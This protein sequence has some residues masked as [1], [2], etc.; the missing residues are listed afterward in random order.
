[1]MIWPFSKRGTTKRDEYPRIPEDMR[2][3]A[4]GDIHGRTDLLKRLHQQILEDAATCPPACEKVVVY[5][6]DY[7]DRGLDSRGVIDLLSSNPLPGFAQVCL[8]GNHEQMLLNFL[9]DESVGEFWFA[10]GGKATVFSYTK[11]SDDPAVSS[12]SFPE[13]QEALRR[14]IPEKHFRFFS[15][16]KF[17]HE[18]GDYFF[19]HAGVRPGTPIEEQDPRDLLWIR[20]EF[21]Q[22]KREH[23][24]VVVHGHSISRKPEIRANR[25]NV[26]T[27]AYATNALTCVVLEGGEQRMISTEGL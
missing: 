25:I 5:V 14:N 3:F 4:V 27:G 21:T 15:R 1:M 12:R 13:I 11:D 8:M 17:C 10:I 9:E 18:I 23:G 7:I 19:A 26:D 16:L 6:G 22:S 20:E 24:K 2:I